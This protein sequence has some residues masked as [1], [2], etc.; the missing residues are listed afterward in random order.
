RENEQ[1]CHSEFLVGPCSKS[2]AAGGDG[3]FIVSVNIQ[4]FLLP[5]PLSV[6]S[7]LNMKF[8]KELIF[9]SPDFFLVNT[10]YHQQPDEVSGRALHQLVA[11]HQVGN[12][13]VRRH[14]RWPR[15]IEQVISLVI[16]P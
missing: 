10:P 6:G 16:N 15:K 12:E 11:T 2:D 5:L 3:V 7:A 4:L 14:S 9:F 13:L 8:V 1:V